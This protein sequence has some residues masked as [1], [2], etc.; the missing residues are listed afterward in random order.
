MA[1]VRAHLS[2]LS[3]LLVLGCVPQQ[4]GPR[5]RSV[6]SLPALVRG[7]G[8]DV[9]LVHGA[10]GDYRIWDGIVSELAGEFRLVA[11]SRRFHWPELASPASGEYT[12]ERQAD[13]LTRFLQI[14]GGKAHLVGHSYGAGVALLVALRHP[15]L[16][17]SLVLIEPPFSTVVPTTEHGFMGEV[18][19][20]DS[21]V[22]RIRAA[23]A[24][25]MD[26]RAAEALMDWVQ[27]GVGR[28][29]DLPPK[30]REQ[31]HANART[32]GP[33]YST[34][35]PRIACD[36]LRGL[37]LPAL[38]VTGRETRL[39]YQLIARHTQQCIP[40]AEASTIRHAGHMVIAEQPAA[41]AAVVAGFLGRAHNAAP[42]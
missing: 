23:V 40:R 29:S 6:A 22:A 5:N 11:I 13:D 26:Q 27:A 2:I 42:R 17:R 15:E 37:R 1:N 41:T 7:T 10:V 20:R 18:A 35:S 21:L 36:D 34:S 8:P 16:I 24:A 39:W 30:V 32:V 4:P 28:F 25:G 31:V 9:V 38:V 19:S 3:L 33:S 12:F 14:R